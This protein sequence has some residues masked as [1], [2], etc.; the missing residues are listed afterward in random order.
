MMKSRQSCSRN[1][2]RGSV[3][4]VLGQN[5]LNG[6][7]YELKGSQS[8]DTIPEFDAYVE[9]RRIEMVMLY[10]TDESLEATRCDGM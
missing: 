1:L 5:A 4:E 10:W 3:L 6:L 8:V 2:R 7:R 9:L